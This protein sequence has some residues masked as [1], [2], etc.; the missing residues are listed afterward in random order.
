MSD[1]R[2]KQD[3]HRLLAALDSSISEDEDGVT[4]LHLTYTSAS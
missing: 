4:V 2:P 3:I 1:S